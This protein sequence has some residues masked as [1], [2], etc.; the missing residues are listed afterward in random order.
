VRRCW[1]DLSNHYPHVTLDAFVIMP[2]H[3]HGIIVLS[4]Y[5]APVRHG[6]P[7][8]MRALKTYSARRI[9]ALRGTPGTSVWQRGYYEHIV[10]DETALGRIREY[11]VANPRNWRK[12]Q[13]LIPRSVKLNDFGTIISGIQRM[14]SDLSQEDWIDRVEW[15]RR[16]T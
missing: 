14:L 13:G 4:G 16:E 1:G 8:I 10:R 9:I 7:E 15:M 12:D 3:V 5:D 2:N 11:I 6:V